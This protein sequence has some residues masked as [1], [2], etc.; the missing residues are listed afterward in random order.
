MNNDGQVGPRERKRAQNIHDRLDVNDDGH[1]GPRERQ[2]AREAFQE[3][4]DSGGASPQPKIRRMLLNRFD[5]NGDGKLGPRERDRA[6][7]AFQEQ[8][9]D[10]AQDSGE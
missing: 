1:V 5:A 7:A 4:S 8:F 3:H 9:G 2:R 6:R 10:K